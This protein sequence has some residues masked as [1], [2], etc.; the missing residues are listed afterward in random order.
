MFFRLERRRLCRDLL[1]HLTVP[2]RA[3]E[4][5]GVG[6]FTRACCRTRFKMKKRVG[7]DLIIGGACY[8]DGDAPE[9]VF[10]SGGRGPIPGHLQSELGW[11]CG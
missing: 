2:K 4:K 1:D 7:L 11:G 6:L 10:S 5:A 8:C 9:Q 3:Y